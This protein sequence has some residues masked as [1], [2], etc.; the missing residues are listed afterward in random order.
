MAVFDDIF[1]FVKPIKDAVSDITGG[2][3]DF[4]GKDG[5]DIIRAFTKGSKIV[6]DKSKDRAEK[7]R[8]LSRKE[9]LMPVG[10]DYQAGKAEYGIPNYAVDPMATERMWQSILTQFMTPN[11]TAVKGPK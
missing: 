10:M 6:G 11:A 5:M 7:A 3:E 4:I 1:D 9:D 8:V 2:V